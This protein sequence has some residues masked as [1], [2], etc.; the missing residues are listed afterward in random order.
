MLDRSS[1]KNFN[2]FFMTPSYGGSVTINYAKSMLALVQALNAHGLK[3]TVSLQ[4]GSSLVTRARNE[5]IVEF[6]ADSTFTHLFFIDADVGFAPET[7]FR[8]LLADKDV[9]AGAYPIKRINW[10]DNIDSSTKADFLAKAT[11]Y[12][13]NAIPADNLL[14]VDSDGLLEVT[15]AP[16]GFMAIKRAVFQQ[17]IE[18]YPELQYVPDWKPGSLN[19]HLCY[20]FFDVMVEPETNRYLSEDY[21]F[22]RRWRDLG[23]K[24]HVDTTAHLSHAGQYV[25]E[26]R[27]QDGLRAAPGMACGFPPETQGPINVVWEKP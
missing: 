17:M 14:I 26:G 12:P 22:C 19:A 23:G 3:G 2:P 13:V 5:G 7:A 10:P 8:L 21:A 4:P 9:I 25:F 27:L 18:K 1:F 20:R 6:L 24:V 15:E 11:R 16:T